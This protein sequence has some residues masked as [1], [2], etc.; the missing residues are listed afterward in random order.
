M[1]VDGYPIHGRYTHNN[2]LGIQIDL[3]TCQGHDHDNL[4]YH[5]HATQ[6]DVNSGGDSWTEYR[7]GPTVCWHGDISQISNF[8]EA[9]KEGVQINYDLSKTKPSFCP[10]VKTDYEDFRPCCGTT[11]FFAAPGVTLNTQAN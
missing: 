8:W 9:G 2:G 4:G 11:Q 1:S 7:I 6:V 5:Y 3:D 10:F